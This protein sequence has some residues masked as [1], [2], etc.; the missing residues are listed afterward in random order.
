MNAVTILD[1]YPGHFDQNGDSGNV[2]ALRRRLEWSGF[3]VDV[4]A[5]D[6]G[7]A[8]PG[9]APDYVLIGG[10]SIPAQRDAHPHLLAARDRLVDWI[11]GGTAFLAVAGG[12]ALAARELQLPGETQSRE[13][14]RIFAGR[15]AALAA[16]QSGPIAFRSD[17]HGV[18]HGFVNLAQRV[19]L[20]DPTA[21]LGRI[22]VGPW[23]GSTGEPEGAEHK[24]AY[25][26]HAHGPILP[27]N[28][29]FADAFIR[30]G[31]LRRGLVDAYRHDERHERVDALA[32]R[33][34]ASLAARLNQPSPD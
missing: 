3:H 27:K 6:P 18:L 12:Y 7:D 11:G 9:D 33:S 26:T 8:W 16:L 29:R 30:A 22:E 21:A 14:L 19:V 32:R 23:P 4:D 10:G 2:L 28:P 15:S 20:D 1:V 24:T 25:G 17:V 5:I 34:R 31:L 13:G